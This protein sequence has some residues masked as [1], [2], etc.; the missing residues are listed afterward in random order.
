MI[1]TLLLKYSSMH[2]RGISTCLIVRI[3]VFHSIQFSSIHLTSVWFYLSASVTINVNCKVSY[4]AW[5]C[6]SCN[7]SD[8]LSN[9][10][11]KPVT[12]MNVNHFSSLDVFVLQNKLQAAT[13]V[14]TYFSAK[15]NAHSYCSSE[16]CL[17]C[18]CLEWL[19]WCK[20]QTD[21]M[22]DILN[23]VCKT[24]PPFP[25]SYLHILS[26]S[27]VISAVSLITCLIRHLM[28]RMWNVFAW[29]C[30]V[31]VLFNFGF[32]IKKGNK[33]HT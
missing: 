23:L 27:L 30:E 6:Q 9:T 2:H 8:T 16:Q 25:C 26:S 13:S 18:G 7:L 19:Q 21:I 20:W 5:H 15:I 14:G 10:Q 1:S 4:C 31:N 33:T 32:D 17:V 22:K 11:I 12:F 3:N 29:K 28:N 24:W